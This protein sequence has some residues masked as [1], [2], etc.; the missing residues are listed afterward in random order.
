MMTSLILLGTAVVLLLVIVAMA[1]RSQLQQARH[2]GAIQATIAEAATNQ[3]LHRQK[4]DTQLDTLH[5]RQR[6]ETIA[7]SA[8]LAARDDF[9][10]DW[11]AGLSGGSAA[12]GHAN[13]SPAAA[14]A[15]GAAIDAKQR[16]ELFD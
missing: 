6:N 5:E 10:N 3:V 13:P 15:S 11:S 9:D 16:N 8:H 7:E 1:Y 12:T 14:D 4:L 2:Y